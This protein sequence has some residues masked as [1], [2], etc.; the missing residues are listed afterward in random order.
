LCTYANK[1]ENNVCCLFNFHLLNGHKNMQH[2]VQV[3]KS[4]TLEMDMYT[5]IPV[6]MLED[7][8]VFWSGPQ[9]RL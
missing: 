8:R 9:R 5:V 6:D 3:K 7:V 4:N 2:H 1:L